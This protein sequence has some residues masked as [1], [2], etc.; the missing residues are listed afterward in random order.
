MK[1]FLSINPYTLE[2]NACR[3]CISR[4]ELFGK[5][6]I[7]HQAFLTWKH[8]PNTEKKDLF[9]KLAHELEKDIDECARLE[10]I[11]MGMLNHV[12]Q[13]GL[14][15]TA[16]LIRWFAEHFEEILAPK[17]YQTE[18]LHV[19]EIRD[20]L[21][22]IFGIAPWN[23]PFNQLLR[24]AVP[25]ILAGNT[26]IYKHA[27]NVPLVAEKIESLFQKAG[28]PDGVY[29]NLFVSSSMSEE[30]I[31]HPY[32]AGV[33]L[34]GSE[35]AGSAVG[36]LAGKYLKPSVLE[37]GGN[38]ALLVLPGANL[39]DTVIQAVQWRIRNGWQACNSSKR[40]LIPEK[41]YDVFVER[42][43]KEMAS[44]KMGD[45]MD[46]AT[47]LQPLA[48]EKSLQDALNQIERAIAS[49]ARLVTGGKKWWEK[50]YFLEPTVLADVTPEV[51]SFQE[52]IFAP[53]ASLVKY[54][55]V[56]EA[57]DLANGTDFWLSA[58]V[59]GPEEEAKQIAQKLDWG[60]IFVN[61]TAASRASLPFGG[62]K[63][64]GY[65]K[66][67]GSDGLL[68]FTNKKVIIV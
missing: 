17:Y 67:N 66:E 68:A 36:S 55:T 30:I 10:T 49:W 9:Y 45:P 62:V 12:S 28:F 56:Q 38:D 13:A 24:A 34:T 8:T 33:N 40:I 22:V 1:K 27:S 2:E 61:S 47:Q 18:W 11:E 46:T 14:Q 29:T 5:I 44:L 42:Y 20:P 58:C 43:A 4:D 64:S 60:M 16:N 59:F 19:Q 53:V 65:G 37:L 57:I 23:F 32:I 63:K 31:S 25:N 52:E 7:A 50:W 51:S 21:W 48:S 26:Q 54:T 15:K 3:E 35:G 39:E 6:Q 41:I